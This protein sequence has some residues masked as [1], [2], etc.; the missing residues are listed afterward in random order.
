MNLKWERLVSCFPDSRQK[1]SK[2]ALQFMQCVN[3]LSHWLWVGDGCGEE[4]VPLQSP[5]KPCPVVMSVACVR[6]T[7]RNQSAKLLVCWITWLPSSTRA[8]TPQ[9]SSS[10][11]TILFIIINVFTGA[12]DNNIYCHNQGLIL[13][14]SNV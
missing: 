10:T 9:L 2:S 13:D 1:H 3:L 4:S 6:E 8:H 12:K 7:P 11:A 5:I 14:N